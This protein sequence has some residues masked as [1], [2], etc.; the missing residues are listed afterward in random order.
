MAYRQYVASMA[1]I[2]VNDVAGEGNGGGSS[3]Q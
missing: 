1:A 3:Y 2:S